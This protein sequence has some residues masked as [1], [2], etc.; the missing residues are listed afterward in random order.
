MSDS[1]NPEIIASFEFV[2]N[3]PIQATFSITPNIQDLNYTHYQDVPSS[4]WTVNH[5][6][7]KYP[8]VTIVSS[9]GERVY[10]DVQYKSPSQIELDFVGAFAGVAYLN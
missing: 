6:L 9:A 7:G 10:A 4:K 2:E 1:N 8:S 5:G 3:D